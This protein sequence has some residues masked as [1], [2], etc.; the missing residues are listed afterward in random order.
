[1]GISSNDGA[2]GGGAAGSP[3]KAGEPPRP[4]PRRAAPRASARSHS[5]GRPGAPARTAP[6]RASAPPPSRRRTSPSPAAAASREA[7]AGGDCRFCVWS[8]G[9][10]AR[11]CCCCC[12]CCCS[13]FG[14]P[15]CAGTNA[16]CVWLK[17]PGA[18]CG[19]AGAP[20]S[21]RAKPARCGG[22]GA[23]P[24]AT[25][26]DVAND[27]KLPL[28]PG[29]A[30]APAPAIPPPPRCAQHR[31]RRGRHPDARDARGRQ[32]R[33]HQGRGAVHP[34]LLARRRARRRELKRRERRVDVQLSSSRDAR[35]ARQTGRAAVLVGAR[36][37][38]RRAR[39]RHGG[40]SVPASRAGASPLRSRTESRG[41][42]RRRAPRRTRGG[43]SPARASARSLRTAAAAA[44][45]AARRRRVAAPRRPPRRRSR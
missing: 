43:P 2:D 27:G 34:P 30:P 38:R 16:P 6:R 28:A 26:C 40:T 21:C 39:R 15:N 8:A 14:V 18:Y 4:P 23:A 1:M 10:H 20:E 9:I 12:C 41:G 17:C 42:A 22:G 35:L 3:K 33:E 24:Y 25:R 45:A 44:A 7:A 5:W 36:F 32:I 37:L 19:A 13:A 31:A 29:P 11:C